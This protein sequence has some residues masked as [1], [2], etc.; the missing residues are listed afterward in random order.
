MPRPVGSKNRSKLGEIDFAPLC[1][2]KSIQAMETILRM[3]E[4]ETTPHHVR[5]QCA[6]EVMNRAW[7]KPKQQINAE[8]THTISGIAEAIEKAQARLKKFEED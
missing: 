1:R 8:V 7:G 4:D 6:Q 3:M 2:R 5:F